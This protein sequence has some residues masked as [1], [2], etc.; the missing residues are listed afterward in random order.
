MPSIVTHYLF[1]EE[2]KNSL[3]NNIQQK[4]T[5]SNNL[6]H[7]FAQS[8]DNLFYYNLLN[9]KSGKK[10]RNFG[11]TAQREK[12][13]EYFKN[14]ILSLKE[15]KMEQNQD[16]LAYLYG[17]LTHYV[18]DSICHPFIIYQAGWIDNENPNYEYR[19]NHEKI[20]VSIDAIYWQEKNNR[21]LYK[22]SLTNLLLPNINFSKDLMNLIGLTYNKTFQMEN[23]GKIYETCVKQGNMIIKFFVTDHFGIKKILYKIFDAIFQKNF[24]K[25][26]YLSFYQKKKQEEYLNRNHDE[27]CNPVNNKLRS[28]ESFDDLY[29]KALKECLNLFYLTDQ[30]LQNKLDLDTYLQF[31][32]DKSYTTGLDW[33]EPSK[34]RFFKKNSHGSPQQ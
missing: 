34:M 2:V 26:Q 8:F 18:L 14:I 3:P 22:E 21:P 23:M 6:Y 32:G 4:L 5:H 24:L 1:S 28:I 9:L 33:K 19:G 29:Q 27:W 30:V 13:N 11:N 15:L 10:I 17:S 25:Y 12:I 31:L 20:E 7:I 16:A